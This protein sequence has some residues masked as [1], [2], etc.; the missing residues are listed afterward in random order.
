[1]SLDRD[2]SIVEDS[3]E[4]GLLLS[5]SGLAGLEIDSDFTVGQLLLSAHQWAY[6][7]LRRKF[8]AAQLALVTNEEGL[9]LGVACRFAE[10]LAAQGLLS[11]GGARA[12]DEGD[13][14]Y[15]GD[16]AI[17]QIDNFKPEF[18]AGDAPRASSEAVPVVRN[19]TSSPSFDT[20]YW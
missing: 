3:G 14:A 5:L 12:A 13:R 16:Q 1:M 19:I 8:T 4:A 6:D 7:R 10:I 17:E 18:S 20:R 9:K 2:T 15:W 11:G